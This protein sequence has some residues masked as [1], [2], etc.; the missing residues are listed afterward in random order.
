MKNQKDED[1]LD[2]MTM[3]IDQLIFT[4][5]PESEI[6][7]VANIID[8]YGVFKIEQHDEIDGELHIDPKIVI[9][10]EDPH[11]F[12]TLKNAGIPCAKGLSVLYLESSR[13]LLSRIIKYLIKKKTQADLLMQAIEL[14]D[15]IRESRDESVRMNAY[16]KLRKIIKTLE[17]E[18]K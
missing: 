7:K 12:E 9:R 14:K 3:K 5:L 4:N 6:I 11:I 13:L 17:S 15:L 1:I 2:S 10:I 18:G 8:E 16:I